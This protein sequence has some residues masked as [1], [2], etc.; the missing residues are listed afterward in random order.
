M[1]YPAQANP[2]IVDS[3]PCMVSI[4]VSILKSGAWYRQKY[5][6][7]SLTN[8]V[9]LMPSSLISEVMMFHGYYGYN[10]QASGAYLN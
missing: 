4:S 10:T 9:H 3:T 1:F 2:L 7:L 8:A 6:I 5:S